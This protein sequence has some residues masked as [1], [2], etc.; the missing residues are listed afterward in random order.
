MVAF[1]IHS[2]ATSSSTPCARLRTRRTSKQNVHYHFAIDNTS[3]KLF[4]ICDMHEINFRRDSPLLEVDEGS[5]P[6]TIMHNSYVTSTVES[7]RGTPG[8]TVSEPDISLRASTIM[9]TDL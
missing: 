4:H 8:N 9:L 6:R 1:M 7:E 3:K 5:P 2:T